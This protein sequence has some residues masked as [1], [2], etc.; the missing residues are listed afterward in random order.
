MQVRYSNSSRGMEE[1]K[2]R[3]KQEMMTPHERLARMRKSFDRNRSVL[4]QDYKY[5]TTPDAPATPRVSIPRN[6][7]AHKLAERSAPKS[8]KRN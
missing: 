7:V 8:P 6:K 2:K 4:T 3:R 1:L 5:F